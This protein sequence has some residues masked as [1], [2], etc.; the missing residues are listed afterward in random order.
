MHGQEDSSNELIVSDEDQIILFTTAIFIVIGIF[1]FMARNIIRRKKTIYDERDLSSKKNKDYEKYH[2][3]WSDDYEELGSKTVDDDEFRNAV[4]EKSLPNYYEVLGVEKNATP[5]EIKKR[6]R[7]LAKELHPDR[8]KN[9]E[10]ENKMAEIN[11]AYEILSDQE[12]RKRYD[13]FLN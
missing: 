5:D 12:K 13:K 1:I 10:T 3:D 2:S 6:F 4:S 8:T 11:K 7:Q 9:P